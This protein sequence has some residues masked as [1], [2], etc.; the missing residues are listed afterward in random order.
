MTHLSNGS[1]ITHPLNTYSANSKQEIWIFGCSFTHGWSLNDEQTYPWLLQEQLP[2]Y[3]I[4]NFGVDAY[5]TVQSLLQFQQGLEKGQKP[6]LVILAY[7]SIHDW[8]NTLERAW[9]KR[10]TP[11]NADYIPGSISLPYMRFSADQ[12]RELKY[13]PLDYHGLALM[14][15]SALANFLDEKYNDSLVETYHSHEISRA[16]IEDFVS[17]CK[18]NEVEFVLAGI[19]PT[20]ATTEMLEYF[21]S[22]GVKTVDISVDLRI[23]ENTNLPYDG[24][25]GATANQQYAQKLESFLCSKLRIGPACASP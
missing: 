2:S 6:V 5:S 14:H 13:M 17:L 19:Y 9:M 20:P 16:L 21:N 1:R 15:Y 12:K 7:S 11:G 23:R 22:K 25:P 4:V 10:R 18:S 24:H 3:E 8:R